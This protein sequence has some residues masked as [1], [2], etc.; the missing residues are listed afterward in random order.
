MSFIIVIG[1]ATYEHL[2]FVPQ[3]TAAPPASLAM[4]QGPYGLRAQDFWIPIHPVTLVLMGSALLVNWRGPRRRTIGLALGGY[5]VVLAVTFA[6]FVPELI[7]ITTT[8]YAT[9]VDPGLQ[10]RAARW[11]TLSLVRLSVLMVLAMVLLSALTIPSGA[12]RKA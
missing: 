6:F 7:A 4:L 11:E 8:P 1:G 2:A 3:W 10:A 12:S 5:V 9:V